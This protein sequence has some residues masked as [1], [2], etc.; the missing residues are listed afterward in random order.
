MLRTSWV[1]AA[2]TVVS[3]IGWV[4]V[5]GPVR[6]AFTGGGVVLFFLASLTHSLATQPAAWT[7]RF[8][9]T[10]LVFGWLVEALGTTTGVPFGAYAYGD[11]LGP[12][13]GPVPV[14][15]PLAW[16]MMAYPVYLAAARACRTVSGR[17]VLAAAL[18]AT[19][20]LFLDPQMVAEGHWW[21]AAAHPALPGIPG[22][23][24]TNF[25]GWAVA[26]L[27]LMVALQ[28]VAGAPPV[29]VAPL[30]PPVVLLAWVYVSNVLANAVFFGRPGVALVG[31]I[32]MGIPLAVAARGLRPP[33]PVAA[34]P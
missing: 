2:L 14:V 21:F 31:A 20:D 25:L 13:V 33:T 7:A 26:A 23:P 19:W 17:L 10:V 18:L 1:L 34:P 27:V 11:R 3:Q 4:L 15:I 32:G 5:A 30:S 24:L 12:D 6:D 22:I 8:F 29:A 16:A 28:A 9:A